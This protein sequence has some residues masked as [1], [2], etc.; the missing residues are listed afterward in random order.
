MAVGVS[1]RGSIRSGLGE[2]VVQRLTAVYL[3]VYH[4][5]HTDILH[6]LADFELYRLGAAVIKFVLS[7]FQPCYLFSAYWHM[8]G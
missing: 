5:Y 1:D 2:W 3:L 4:N 6:N 8:P 7:R